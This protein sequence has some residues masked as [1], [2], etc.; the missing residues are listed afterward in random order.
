M[1]HATTLKAYPSNPAYDCVF[2][3]LYSKVFQDIRLVSL[4]DKQVQI[5]ATTFRSKI[6]LFCISAL[7][8]YRNVSFVLYSVDT[9]SN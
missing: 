2:H 1:Q 6:S 8:I 5:G 9:I 3:P 4:A 7:D